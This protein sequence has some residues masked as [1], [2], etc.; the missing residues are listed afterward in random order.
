VEIQGQYILLIS[1][2]PEN[3]VGF[4][5]RHSLVGVARTDYDGGV[6]SVDGFS[7]DRCV[8]FRVFYGA[9]KIRDE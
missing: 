4:P 6:R 9:E 3:G 5:V 1:S 7:A 8:W 2:L